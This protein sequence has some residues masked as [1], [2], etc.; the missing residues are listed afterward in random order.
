MRKIVAD[1]APPPGQT[2][3]EVRSRAFKLSAE[4]KDGQGHRSR[5]APA[6]ASLTDRELA[7]IHQAAVIGMLDGLVEAFEAVRSGREG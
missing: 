3:A 6:P 2:S 1:P 4:T 5:T 7:A